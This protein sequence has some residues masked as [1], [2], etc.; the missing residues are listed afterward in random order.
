MP[1]LSGKVERLTAPFRPAAFHDAVTP[2][3]PRK[4]PVVGLMN[5]LKRSLRESAAG[6]ERAGASKKTRGRRA[7]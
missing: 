1:R 2:E 5:A 7:A 3:K 4:A 6:N